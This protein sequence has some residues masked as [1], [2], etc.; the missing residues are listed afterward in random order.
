[1]NESNGILWHSTGPRLEMTRNK[2]NKDLEYARVLHISDLTPHF[3]VH[4]DLKWAF[5]RWD[6]IRIGWWF[7]RRAIWP[8]ERGI[9]D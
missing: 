4:S 3:K 5:S 6:M 8:T 9:D 2:S 7:M 1:M